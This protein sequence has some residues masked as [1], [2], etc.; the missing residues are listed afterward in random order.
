MLLKEVSLR[1]RLSPRLM[2]VPAHSRSQG[3]QG[4][5][6]RLPG[7]DPGGWG[8]Q[9]GGRAGEAG[10]VRVSI[11]WGA[12]ALWTLSRAPGSPSVLTLQLHGLLCLNSSERR[13]CDPTLQVE[14]LRPRPL[15]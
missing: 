5:D 12:Q 10:L 1:L 14:K 3:P 15:S 4:A 8:G 6:T 9:G 2:G 13:D 11:C 7:G